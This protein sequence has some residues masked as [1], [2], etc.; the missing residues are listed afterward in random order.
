MELTFAQ[1]ARLPVLTPER[2]VYLLYGREQVLLEEALGKLLAG[3]RQAAGAEP[4]VAALY[5]NGTT[6]EQIAGELANLSLLG[7]GKVVVV[8]EAQR[9]RAPEQNRLAALLP[10]LGAG[11]LLVLLAGEPTY[12][13]RTRRRKVLGEKL[14]SAVRAV[15]VTIEFPTFREQDAERWLLTEAKEAGLRLD[16][17]AA[18]QMVLLAGADLLRLRNELAKVLAYAGTAGQVSVEEISQVV[19]RSPEATI[20]EL[21]DAIGDRRPDQALAALKILL[22]AGEPEQRILVLLARQ[23]RLIWQAKYLAERGF[24]KRSGV[25]VP[26][27]VARDLLPRDSSLNV[28][29][30]LQRPFLREKL[31]RQAQAFSW[32]ALRQGLERVLAADLAFKGIEGEVDNPRL[33]LEMLVLTLAS[34]GRRAPVAAGRGRFA[35]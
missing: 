4:D 10:R 29:G 31:L 15:G 2:P 34:G 33:M 9:L 5:G 1:I 3:V 30:Q 22:D 8:R 23:I 21:I 20:F 26:P 19:S 27:E 7:A 28:M 6:C 12:D 17:Q 24:V 32:P 35:R 14:E 13:S 18:A 11:S 16:P 25:N